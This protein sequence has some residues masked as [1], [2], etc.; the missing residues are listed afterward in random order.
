M[1]NYK[2]FG[3]A[4]RFG[5]SHNTQ[6]SYLGQVEK[7]LVCRLSRSLRQDKEDLLVVPTSA[8][9]GHHASMTS[10]IR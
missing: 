10:E 4:P 7:G 8:T 6:V 9:R 5:Q 3:V 1:R 2:K